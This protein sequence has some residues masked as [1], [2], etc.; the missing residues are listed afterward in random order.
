MAVGLR[1]G[2]RV[3]FAIEF[4]EEPAGA[5]SHAEPFVAGQLHGLA[6]QYD[7]SG[8]LLMVSLFRRGTGTDFWCDQ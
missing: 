3:G 2:V 1:L 7:P 5:A 4:H 8:R 6:R